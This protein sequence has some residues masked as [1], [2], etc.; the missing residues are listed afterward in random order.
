MFL[1]ININNDTHKLINIKILIKITIKWENMLFY[2][3]I[4]VE[5]WREK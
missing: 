1:N 5:K 2:G 3:I 4:N